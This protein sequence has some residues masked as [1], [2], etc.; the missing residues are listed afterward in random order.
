[1][2]TDTHGILI[3]LHIPEL[4][5]E[6]RIWAKFPLVGT[7][8]GVAGVGAGGLYGP[9]LPPDVP[10]PPPPHATIF[11]HIAVTIINLIFNS[12]LQRKLI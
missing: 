11:K 10:L 1:M 5:W 3:L 9:L 7:G 2:V 4:P 8:V 6:I 12:Y